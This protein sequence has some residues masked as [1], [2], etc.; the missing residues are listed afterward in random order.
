MKYY[1]TEAGVEFLDEGRVKKALAVGALAAGA[2]AGANNPGVVAKTRMALNP[3][4]RKAHVGQPDAVSNYFKNL[5]KASR[6]M[7]DIPERKSGSAPLA[8]RKGSGKSGQSSTSEDPKGMLRGKKYLKFAEKHVE[9]KL[10]K[11]YPGHPSWS[12]NR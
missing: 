2:I 12:W 8:P 10:R 4:L 9:P 1:L 6:E 7:V 5:S 3:E 11:A